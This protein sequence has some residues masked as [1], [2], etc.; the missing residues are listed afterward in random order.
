MVFSI[1][2]TYVS[3]STKFDLDVTLSYEENLF[4]MLK[5]LKLIEPEDEPDLQLL[6][7]TYSIQ[8]ATKRVAN[9]FYL[10]ASFFGS[11]SNFWKDI[12]IKGDEFILRNE[13]KRVEDKLG[14]LR[15]ALHEATTTMMVS[16]SG[17]GND[18]DNHGKSATKVGMKTQCSILKE[19]AKEEEATK[20]EK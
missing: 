17:G 3:S 8:H 18:V 11:C 6:A 2:L 9:N 14:I 5:I 10:E 16:G 19:D 13:Y 7:F 15:K 12:A 4:N 1:Q 20:E